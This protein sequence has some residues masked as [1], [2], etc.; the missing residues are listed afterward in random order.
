VE[1][2]LRGRLGAR[3]VVVHVEPEERVR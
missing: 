1:E 3:R 2:E